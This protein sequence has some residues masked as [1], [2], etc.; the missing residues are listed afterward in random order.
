MDPMLGTHLNLGE[1]ELFEVQIGDTRIFCHHP[2]PLK[3][4]GS[5]VQG[6][7]EKGHTLRY[8][9]TMLEA[10]LVTHTRP[11]GSFTFS[12]IARL[13]SEDAVE[14]RNEGILFLG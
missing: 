11:D 8:L 4:W 12:I 13:E 1:Y 9:A 7:A 5:L 2:V 3:A 14:E 6:E 10:A